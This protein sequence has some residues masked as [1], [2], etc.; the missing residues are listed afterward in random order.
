MFGADAGTNGESAGMALE[1]KMKRKVTSCLSFF[2]GRANYRCGL[3]GLAMAAI[4]LGLSVRHA[5]GQ[6]AITE[7]MSSAS[8]NGAGQN[9]ADFWEL[10]NFST[11]EINLA[12]YRWNDNGGGRLGDFVPLDGLIISNLESIVFVATNTAIP[13]EQAFRDW[14]GTGLP[15]KTR[16]V[17]FTG[18]GLSASGDGLRL[19]GPAATNDNDVIDSVDFGVAR[20]G[21][22]FTYDPVTGLFGY[23][24][25]T[26][27]GGVFQS[28]LY[29][30]IGS[31][32]VTAGPVPIQIIAQPASVGVCAGIDA[33]FSVVAGGLPRPK[34]RWLF[35]GEPV[36]GATASALAI[37]NPQPTN[38]GSYQVEISS[39][40]NVILSTAVT[41]TVDAAD[42]PPTVF[43]P[44]TDVLVLSNETARFFAP[45][46]AF[47]PPTFQWLSNGIIVAG[48]TNRM[49]VIKNCRPAASGALF[50]VNITN[51][52]GGTSICARLT[53]QPKPHLVI[54]EVMP[55]PSTNCGFSTDWFEV[56]NFGS[57]PVNL[58]GYRFAT[59][60]GV[61][62]SLEG[63]R[64]VTNNAIIQPGE[65]AVFV[66]RYDFDK[67]IEWWGDALPPHLVL[68]PYSGI[69]LRGTTDELYLWGPGTEDP[70]DLITYAF[71]AGSSI[72]VSK[73]FLDN[74]DGQ[75]FTTV[76]GERGA[77]VAAQ[78]SDIGSPGY[79]NNP[80]PR[81]TR[82][83]HDAAGATLRWRAVSNSTYH[84]KWKS[85]L[86]APTATSLV[87]RT[88][89]NWVETFVDVS[90][91]NSGPRFYFLEKLP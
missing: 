40:T 72:G 87:T 6:L 77:F 73:Y 44:F 12:G 64:R 63:A 22:T 49:L 25:V 13:D 84:L 90:V 20:R 81:F 10:T 83:L 9:L 61:A 71:W 11:N 53:V 3:A 42:K 2:D 56:T 15:A 45:V 69:G 41:L 60:N 68:I 19:W 62:A 76:P 5:S 8:M 33:A 18:N 74:V 89:T 75:D 50:C 80:P 78:C 16:I 57:N 21:S 85:D 35:N 86:S 54:T 65:S 51:A 37:P 36:L 30:D 39:G 27:D 70:L 82:I 43:T 7:A 26:N 66:R 1:T 47:P 23:F 46:C 79:T 28:A 67:F 88:A 48:A 52:L 59:G 58:L 4:L 24:S 38:A 34:Y 14:W 32:G 55:S 31:P 29:N 91:T 17:L